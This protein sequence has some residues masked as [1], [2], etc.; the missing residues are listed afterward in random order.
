MALVPAC[1]VPCRCNKIVVMAALCEIDTQLA[2]IARMQP[3]ATILTRDCDAIFTRIK[4]CF[5]MQPKLGWAAAKGRKLAATMLQVCC[6]Q[7]RIEMAPRAA[8]SR[9][10]DL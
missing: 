7:R 5:G 10:H 9:Q 8:M 4:V 1:L 3:D 6:W 2:Q